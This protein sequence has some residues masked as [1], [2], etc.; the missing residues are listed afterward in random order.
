MITTRD[1]RVHRTDVNLQCL[2]LNPTRNH[3][4]Q[5]QIGLPVEIRISHK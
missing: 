3:I 2:T 1:M 5:T 4:Q